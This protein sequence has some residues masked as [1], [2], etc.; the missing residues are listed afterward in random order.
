MAIC[1]DPALTF[2]NGLGYNV[3]RLPRA[4][5]E[6]LDI[7]GKDT[8]IERLGRVDQMWT[9]DQPLP[10]ITGPRDATSV[11]GQKTSEMKLSVGLKL[12]SAT[13][14]A[15]GAA[16]PEVS[17]AFSKARKVVFTFTDVKTFSAEP[18]EVGQYLS[19]GDLATSN[20]FVRRY[21]DDEETS[22]FII[23]E[24]LKSTSITVTAT[25][26]RGV[27]VGVDVPAIVQAVGAKVAVTSTSSTNAT[28]TFT[29]TELLTFGF[30]CFGIAFVDGEWNVIS[31][32][33][34]ADL[35]F[36]VTPGVAAGTVSP[37]ILAP[38]RLVI[39]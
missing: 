25:N 17:M 19:A 14:G 21:F 28:L 4:G 8:T 36:S 13:L 31:A 10:P 39:R 2:L 5:V 9:S 20:P 33:P 27:E 30:K 3:V 38:G 24:V 23:T 6:P 16:V 26:D 11:A 18:L 7:L 22:A 35:A 37:A 29:G 34:S 12:L 32:A 1:K 15:M